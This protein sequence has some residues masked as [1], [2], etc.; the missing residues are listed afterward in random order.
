MKGTIEE[1]RS[2][3]KKSEHKEKL[4]WMTQKHSRT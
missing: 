2:A 1:G 4:E 3:I